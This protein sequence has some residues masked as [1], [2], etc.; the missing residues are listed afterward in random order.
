MTYSRTSHRIHVNNLLDPKTQLLPRTNQ[1]IKLGKIE[2]QV[3]TVINY[4]L[5]IP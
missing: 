3:E 2:E 5:H 1:G 4:K